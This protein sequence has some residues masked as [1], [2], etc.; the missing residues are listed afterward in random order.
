MSYLTVLPSRHFKSVHCNTC[1]QT[2]TLFGFFLFVS[3]EV[4][5]GLSIGLC[6][7]R[8]LYTQSSLL[9]AWGLGDDGTLK[10]VSLIAALCSGLC[11]SPELT[12]IPLKCSWFLRALM[13][14]ICEILHPLGTL[15]TLNQLE[16]FT[17]SWVFTAFTLPRMSCKAT[18]E[19]VILPSLLIGL[20]S[21]FMSQLLGDIKWL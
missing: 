4:V 15:R 6:N 8:V 3:P 17:Y 5:I 11:I 10:K 20:T 21:L 18:M 2:L 14:V 9:S 16:A 12:Q 13:L 7:T 19:T 1:H